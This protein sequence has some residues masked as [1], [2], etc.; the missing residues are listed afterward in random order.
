MTIA[1]PIMKATTGFAWCAGTSSRTLLGSDVVTG[2]DSAAEVEATNVD[3]PHV[4]TTNAA[5]YGHWVDGDGD[6]FE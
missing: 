6:P 1:R 4:F 2:V 5:M 3:I